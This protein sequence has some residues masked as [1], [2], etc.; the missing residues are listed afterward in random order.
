MTR[1][2]RCN[3]AC[4]P[5]H[6]Q[7]YLRQ[8]PGHG[9]AGVTLIG[10]VV[11]GEVTVIRSG[12]VI[13]GPAIH[14]QNCII[15]P[16]YIGPYTSIGDNSTIHGGEI[17]ASILVGDTLL[18][19]EPEKRITDSLVGRHSQIYSATRRLPHSFKLTLGENS[20]VHI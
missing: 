19:L 5:A 1:H 17:E 15:G 6:A 3:P 9:E 14:R 10:S 4:K 8:S 12:S 2:E 18:D 11:V 20:E 7:R 16:T 13:R